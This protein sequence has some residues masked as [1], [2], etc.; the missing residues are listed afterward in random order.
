MHMRHLLGCCCVNGR[1]G[2][3]AGKGVVGF[4]GQSVVGLAFLLYF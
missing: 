4:E 3:G 2:D 1:G